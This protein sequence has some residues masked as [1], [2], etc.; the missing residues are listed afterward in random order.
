MDYAIEKAQGKFQPMQY[1]NKILATYYQRGVKT[2]EDA[3]NID[4]EFVGI[5]NQN[6]K[7]P[8]KSN[9]TIITHSY[10]EEELNSFF[11]NLDELDI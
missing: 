4:N 6:V 3:K 5:N 2:L 8:Q 11:T 10:T 7:A 9:N 1:L